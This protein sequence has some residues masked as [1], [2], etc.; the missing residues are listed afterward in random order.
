M[1]TTFHHSTG[2]CRVGA[3]ACGAATPTLMAGGEPKAK[4]AVTGRAETIQGGLHPLHT[5]S[6]VSITSKGL[7]KARGEQQ[8]PV[9]EKPLPAPASAHRETI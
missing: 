4:G 1:G 8:S 9:L 7:G 2:V 3:A 5:A 6:L